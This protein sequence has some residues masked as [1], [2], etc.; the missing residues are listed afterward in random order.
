[1]IETDYIH[2]YI[3]FTRTIKDSEQLSCD[4]II[5]VREVY[6]KEIDMPIKVEWH[7]EAKTVVVQRY[8]GRWTWDE[9][10]IACT[11]D[12][13]NL[14]RTVPHTVHIFADFTKAQGVPIGGAMLHAR[15]V[16]QHYPPNWGTLV[17]VGANHFI[18]LLVEMFRR[19]FSTTLGN[20]TF[21]AATLEDAYK[22]IESY[23]PTTDTQSE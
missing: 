7:N 2:F 8:D 23:Q 1:M 18:N 11:R 19:T 21:T 20:K 3:F 15:N 13:S 6:R 4:T 10:H 9:F 17:I 16:M 22:L 12:T 14:M 5:D